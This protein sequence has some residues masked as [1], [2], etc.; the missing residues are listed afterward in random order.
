LVRYAKILLAKAPIAFRKRRDVSYVQHEKGELKGFRFLSGAAF[1]LQKPE[2]LQL[3][4]KRGRVD[5]VLGVEFRTDSKQTIIHIVT[6]EKGKELLG[7]LIKLS[8]RFGSMIKL[9]RH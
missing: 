6:S 8:E 3:S 4:L 7:I 2:D 1:R 5:I 9:E